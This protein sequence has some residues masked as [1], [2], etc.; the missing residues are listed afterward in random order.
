[1]TSCSQLTDIE[2]LVTGELPQAC[3]ERLRA[4]AAQ[5]D[6]CAAELALLTAERALFERRAKAHA[7]PPAALSFVLRERLAEEARGHALP[8]GVRVASFVGR[9]V[10]RGH[11]SA[12]CAA[13]LFLVAAFSRMG[14]ATVVA[15][16]SSKASSPFSPS[17][18]MSSSFMSSSSSSS[19]ESGDEASSG[20]GML[21]SFGGDEPR[22]C[23]VGSATSSQD[24]GTT[25]GASSLF[26][27]QETRA[28]ADSSSRSLGGCEPFVTCSA[29]RQ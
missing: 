13:A 3:A 19:S 27:M 18:F 24:E 29:L 21:A 11:L 17:S 6:Q 16:S 12:A 20:A 7:P 5:C 15:P 22:A 23:V 4:H 26:S 25:R 8:R 28:C 9:I 14:T 1:M 2:E 10:R